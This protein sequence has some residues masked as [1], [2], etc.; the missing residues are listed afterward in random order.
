MKPLLTL[1]M[2]FLLTTIGLHA[3]SPA[4]APP[5]DE[6]NLFLLV[7]A[8]AFFSLILGAVIVGSIATAGLLLFLFTLVSVGILS[9]SVIV[10]LYKRSFFAGFKTLLVIVCGL[11]GA[12]GG[13]SIMWLV[14]R[15]FTLRLSHAVTLG[16]GALGG[17][18]GGMLLGL[19]VYGIIRSLTGYFKKKLTLAV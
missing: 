7:F 4:A 15:L 14:N 2:T 16:S 3:Q 18:T 12:I 19:C 9:T 5:D 11:G 8:I 1:F 10:G 17:L 13:V 6:F